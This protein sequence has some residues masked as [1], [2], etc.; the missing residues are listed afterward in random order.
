[1]VGENFGVCSL[2][3]A[4]GASGKL[5]IL[6]TFIR[7][8]LYSVSVNP[9]IQSARDS[10]VKTANVDRNNFIT[11]VFDNKYEQNSP[12]SVQNDANLSLSYR[13]YKE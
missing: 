4:S 13:R 9:C 7:I 6:H 10:L 5:S 11:G 2:C 12:I 1:M 8:L 3:N